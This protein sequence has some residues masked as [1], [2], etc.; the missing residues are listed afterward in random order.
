MAFD[1]KRETKEG[2]LLQRGP[3]LHGQCHV[4]I[5]RVWMNNYLQVEVSNCLIFF[6]SLP[7]LNIWFAGGSLDCSINNA[8]FLLISLLSVHNMVSPCWCLSFML[9]AH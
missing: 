1:G 5:A 3:N 8:F 7:F 6:F 2:F 9:R 4:L